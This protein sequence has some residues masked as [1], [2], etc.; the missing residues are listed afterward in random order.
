MEL[1]LNR[2]ADMGFSAPIYDVVELLK[3][4]LGVYV[5]KCFL[6]DVFIMAPLDEKKEVSSDG[7]TLE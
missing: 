7:L 5:M 1:G 2:L 4:L 6:E 3:S